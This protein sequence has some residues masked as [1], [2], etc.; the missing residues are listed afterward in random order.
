MTKF[1]QMGQVKVLCVA[2]GLCTW[3]W[4][5]IALLWSP[6]STARIQL[7]WLDQEQLSWTMRSM[8]RNYTQLITDLL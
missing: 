4:G 6:L 3:E 7:R 1:W 2:S 8:S 5:L